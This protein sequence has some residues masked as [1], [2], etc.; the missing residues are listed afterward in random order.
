[1]TVAQLLT[2]FS[3]KQ[4]VNQYVAFFEENN[5]VERIH[6]GKA[7]RIKVTELGRMVTNW[8]I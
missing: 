3:S 4:N 1:M 2:E 8:L 6:E 7:V 5:L